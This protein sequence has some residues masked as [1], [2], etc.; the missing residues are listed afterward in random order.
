[1]G[2]KGYIMQIQPF[3][4][5]DGEGIRTDIF[6]AGCPLRC[7]W[8]SNPEG[9][10]QKEVIGWHRRKCI[11][12]GACSAVCPQGIGIEMDPDRDQ[13]IAC[14]ACV[15]ACPE[16]A[17]AGMVTLMDADDI[18]REIHKHR[19]FYSYSGGGVT[20]SG[21]EA[22][23][24]PELLDYLSRE[25]YD[26]GYSL[27]IETCGYFDFDR[28]RPA[29]ERMDLIFM[30]LK[31]MDPEVHRNYTGVS[32]E[33][34]LENMSKLRALQADIVIRVPVIGGVNN[35]EENIT[36]SAAY[37]HDVLPQ[38]RMELLPYHRLGKIKY[39]A[40][41]MEFCQDD[42]YTPDKTEMERLREIVAAQ[43]VIL[44]DYR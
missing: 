8:C 16:G 27:D 12:C 15:R 21:G 20:F 10:R 35:S 34:I 39:D 4:V 33:K 24:Q 13:C 2:A 37:V 40:L 29:L 5:N 23:S 19:L 3:S 38:A 6:I 11:G 18:I 43:G 30:D 31:H 14:G 32:N 36:A 7:R 1:M 44:A 9:F 26:M 28:V 25:L 17:R 22:T 41:G 42:F